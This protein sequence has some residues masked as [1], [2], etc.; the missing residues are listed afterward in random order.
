MS[1]EERKLLEIEHSRKRRIILRGFER[2]S[3]TNIAYQTENLDSLIVNK[4]EFNC[5]FSN[6]KFYSITGKSE[7]YQ[8]GWLKERC[9]SGVKVLDFGCGNGENGIYAATCG[10]EVMGIDISPEGVANANS[11]A[12]QMN[13]GSRCKFEV[14][15]GENMSFADD[16]FDIGVEYGVLHHV[17]LDRVMA[18]LCRV[19][20]PNG[21]MICIEALRHNPLIHW[22]RKRTPH[23]R[24]KWET[25]H[26]LGVEDLAVARKYFGK[27][28]A[29]F[30]HLTVL[31]A[32]PFRKSRLFKV[33]SSFLD[34]VDSILLNNSFLGKYAWIMVVVLGDPK[35]K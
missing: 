9:C 12:K 7:E 17:C 24:T 28:E 10:A 35:N 16:T 21:E 30:F 22:Y 25:E 14:M 29:K 26:I 15:D 34:K 11:N 13:V 3:D 33:F 4:E 2:H 8:Y 27:V 1:L 5:Y 20:K 19:I 18:E 6:M 31:M 32:V 23:L